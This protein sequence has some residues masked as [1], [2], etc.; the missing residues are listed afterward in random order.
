MVDQL[1][2]AHGETRGHP[3]DLIGG[4]MFLGCVDLRTESEGGDPEG[5]LELVLRAPVL[6]KRISVSDEGKGEGS[7]EQIR[8]RAQ[9]QAEEA[10]GFLRPP[11]ADAFCG[12]VLAR[13]GI[14]MFGT[15]VFCFD[16]VDYVEAEK[17]GGGKFKP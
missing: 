11:Y 15:P 10:L 9:P 4:A 1:T 5:L 12:S 2:D 3:M 17:Q 16:T 7:P 14:P 8:V 13:L 6:L